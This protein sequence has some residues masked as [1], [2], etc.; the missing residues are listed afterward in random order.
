MLSAAY[1]NRE[2][3]PNCARAEPRTN[4]F[5]MAA[6]VTSGARETVKVRNMSSNGALV[7]GPVLP[8]AG[9]PCLLHRGDLSLEAHVVWVKP[10]K[11]GI[12]F[13]NTADVGQWLPSGRRTQSEVD[14]AVKMAKAEFVSA[15]APKTPAPLFSTELS[16]EEVNHTAAAME[17]LADELAD[18]PA[19]VAR[20]MTKLQTL[21]IAAQTLRKLATQIP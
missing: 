13:R 4:M 21:D 19:V 7:E 18:D 2:A 12:R 6:L 15:P 10:G 5:V 3:Y 16:R 1:E 9:T 14:A 20:F 8:L 17:A 11:A